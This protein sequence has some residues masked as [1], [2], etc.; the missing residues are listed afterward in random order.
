MSCTISILT[1]STSQAWHWN[2]WKPSTISVQLLP[3]TSIT[4]VIGIGWL[5]IRWCSETQWW[6]RH[7]ISIPS[8]VVFYED[9]RFSTLI[10]ILPSPQR[11]DSEED[12][13]ETLNDL[14]RPLS[15]RTI[16]IS[17]LKYWICHKL[18][19]L[20]NKTIQTTSFNPYRYQNFIALYFRK[21]RFSF[22]QKDVQQQHVR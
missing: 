22:V 21:K 15:N 13:L 4:I 18:Y 2:W 20:K 9:Y 3:K 5:S 8:R 14:L 16:H 1:Y 6:L 19:N 7:I 12:H 11:L 17:F 10:L